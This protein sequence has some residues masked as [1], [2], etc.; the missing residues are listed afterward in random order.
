[1]VS[2]LV[3]I[4]SKSS[5]VPAG[6]SSLVLARLSTKNRFRQA[7]SLS[8]EY[9]FGA[10]NLKRV[11]CILQLSSYLHLNVDY[12]T[13]IRPMASMARRRVTFLALNISWSPKPIIIPSPN[14][15][16]TLSIIEMNTPKSEVLLDQVMIDMGHPSLSIS[17]P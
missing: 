12:T 1:M 6:N 17:R 14:S 15:I 11:S 10:T 5:S 7:I 3:L 9:S 4:Y 2:I 8:P 13:L 16:L